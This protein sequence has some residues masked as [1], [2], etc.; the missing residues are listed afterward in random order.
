MKMGAMDMLTHKKV[1]S[2]RMAKDMWFT[3]QRRKKNLATTVI[4][5]IKLLRKNIC[6]GLYGCA[7]G[8]WVYFD[9]AKDE[10]IVLRNHYPHNCDVKNKFSEGTYLGILILKSS[11]HHCIITPGFQRC[12]RQLFTDQSKLKIWRKEDWDELPSERNFLAIFS[13]WCK[14]KKSHIEHI[15]F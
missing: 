11:G 13:C 12:K 9:E 10:G 6:G 15:L 7:L 3:F 8:A 1:D 4:K 2:L 5:I 14:V